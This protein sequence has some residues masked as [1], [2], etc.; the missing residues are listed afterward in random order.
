MSTSA[1][2]SATQRKGKHWLLPLI[3]ITLALL[4]TFDAQQPSA[5]AFTSN[6]AGEFSQ[7]N[8]LNH[9]KQITQ[10]PHFLGSKAHKNVQQYIQTQLEAMGLEVEIFEHL[11]TRNKRYFS[12]A[13]TQNII[14]KIPGKHQANEHKKSM[15][16]V[17]HY[18]SGLHSSM[19]ASDAGSGVVTILEG[20]RAFIERGQTPENDIIIIITDGE[21][22]GLLGAQAFV[23]YH[24]WAENVELVLNFEA[25][26][27]GGPSYMILET[28]QGNSK[29]VNAFAKANIEHPAA[30]SLMYSIYKMLPNDTDLTVFREDA[31][32]QGF[33]FAFIDDHFDY[34]TVQDSFVRLDRESLNHQ[35]EYLMALLDYFAMADLTKLRSDIDLVYFNVPLL[36]MV[37]YPFSMVI[38]MTVI[39][40]ILLLHVSFVGIKR[41]QV[42]INKLC[43][44]FVPLTI[45][46]IS[47]LAIGYLGWHGLLQ[48][49]P[50][51]ADIAQNFTYNGHW[52]LASFVALTIASTLA[53]AKWFA[54]YCSAADRYFAV[55]VCW[56]LINALIAYVLP[57]A[58]FLIIPVYCALLGMYIKIYKG[59]VT[60]FFYTGLLILLAILAAMIIAPL[61]P[62]LVIGL[63]L[64]AMALGTVLTCLLVALV[65][66]LLFSDARVKGVINLAVI[67]STF[68]FIV[69]AMQST[70]TADR[71]KPN[72]IN[73]IVDHDAQQA[74]WLSSNKTL[75]KFTQQ[76]FSKPQQSEDWQQ[77]LYPNARSSKVRF[78]E[79]THVIPLKAA[80]IEVINDNNNGQERTLTIQITPQ[81]AT[82]LLQL[83]TVNS[84]E[85]KH[86]MVNGQSLLKQS[87]AI[88][89]SFEPG[90]FFSY[91]LSSPLEKI[92]IELT[93]STANALSLKVFE[94]AFDVFERFKTIKP[95][96]ELF[97]PE[98]FIINDATIIRQSVNTKL[99]EIIP[100]K[101]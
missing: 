44:G 25:R 96:G 100:S 47:A 94:T 64:K 86:I 10:A 49:Y 82:H 37:T 89:S 87:A 43:L 90:F 35:A 38:W 80:K 101:Y 67:I 31:D 85:I 19:G 48:I 65:A 88:G 33:N 61:I 4:F 2:N 20:L 40:I 51:Y 99:I 26:G 98:P 73:Y 54:R 16:L 5:T 71:K 12:A 72:S 18:D 13:N 79:Q 95:R 23:N 75:D 11:G 41:Q 3:A 50:Q 83:S 92:T 76:F 32:I 57:G 69:S 78:F 81:K 28:N 60:S 97:M 45:S 62:A 56:L 30:N 91:T 8:A 21:E 7:S 14:A 59:E 42:S 55:L 39:A 93:V 17:S 34:H 27:S 53:I 77:S 68:C 29:L 1:L 52:I 74:F 15:A 63:G 84:L 36:G 46:I 9:L 58:G 6:N 24:P 66:P 22:R 70:Y